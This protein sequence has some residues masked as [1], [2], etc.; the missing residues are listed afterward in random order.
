MNKI[1]LKQILLGVV[2]SL[3]IVVGVFA[4][5]GASFKWNDAELPENQHVSFSATCNYVG[6]WYQAW[7]I[8]LV[9][10]KSCSNI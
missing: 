3:L 8:K 4:V 5:M 2:V 1:N 10:L 7:N 6:I 9:I